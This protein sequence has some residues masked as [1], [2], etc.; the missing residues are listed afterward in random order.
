MPRSFT[1]NS[2][3]LRRRNHHYIDNFISIGSSGNND[4]KAVVNYGSNIV[5]IQI[6][7]LVRE[8]FCQAIAVYGRLWSNEAQWR[9]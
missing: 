2:I 7:I 8:L 4:N 6:T 5:T 3:D 9:T 1:A